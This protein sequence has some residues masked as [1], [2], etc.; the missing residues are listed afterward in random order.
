MYTEQVRNWRARG[1]RNITSLLILLIAAGTSHGQPRNHKL[2]FHTFKSQVPPGGLRLA[3]G[4]IVLPQ[5]W[6]TILVASGYDLFDAQ[7]KPSPA[8]C[9]G[10]FIGPGLIVTAAHCFDY[11]SNDFN[12]AASIQFGGLPEMALQCRVSKE[13]AESVNANVQKV[14]PRVPED[15]ALCS[16]QVPLS[17]PA[18]LDHLRYEVVDTGTVLGSG[19]SVLLTGY[20]CGAFHMDSDGGLTLD[21]KDNHLR[22]GNALI[23]TPAAGVNPLEILSEATQP[24]LCPG[25]SGAPMMS[26]VTAQHPT[27]QRRVAGVNSTFGTRQVTDGHYVVV[28]TI[29]ALSSPSFTTLA[30][31]WLCDNPGGVVC[32]INVA[33]R[34]PP[35]AN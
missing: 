35:C 28:S 23:S 3:G 31:G 11:G 13:Y 24:A 27:G 15:Y 26:N 1:A 10:T 18:E 6:A 2:V 19:T 5:D 34:A 14:P 30:K 20:G 21:K 25:D 9:T 22:I 17:P 4:I 29:A 8:S 33:A 32:G 12:L 7:G 16:F